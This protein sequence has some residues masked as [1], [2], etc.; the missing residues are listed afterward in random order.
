MAER[1]PSSGLLSPLA[2]RNA[3]PAVAKAL[4]D[5]CP[6]AL[7]P[8]VEA[9][10]RRPTDACPSATAASDASDAAPQAAQPDAEDHPALAAAVVEKLVVPAPDG[11][12]PGQPI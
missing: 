6:D 12:V 5:G 11:P 4:P 3:A 9:P 7:V 8:A 1:S 2:E 10:D